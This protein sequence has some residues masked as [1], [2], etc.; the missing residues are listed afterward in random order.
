MDIIAHPSPNHGLRRDAAVPSMIILH[1]TAMATAEAAR[2]RLCDPAFEV[3]AHY[4][5]AEDGRIWQLVDE[6]RRA[7]HAGVGAWMDVR[8]VNSASIGIELANDGA[9]PFAAPLMDSLAWLIDDVRTRWVI[10]KQRILGHSDIALGRKIDPGPRLDWRRLS[11]GGRA[12]W[13]DMLGESVDLE[14][15]LHRI[16]YRAGSVEQQLAAFRLRFRP[17]V[18][19]PATETDRRAVGAVV[20]LSEALV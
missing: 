6:E 10:P 7:W 18:Q 9:S 12:I 1:Y 20:S 14:E 13:P 15:G 19:G 4:L 17:G 11:I 8:D 16:G 2:D 3:S 5:I